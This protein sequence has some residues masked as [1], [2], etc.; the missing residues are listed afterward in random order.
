MA[1]IGPVNRRVAWADRRFSGRAGD[2]AGCD[3]SRGSYSSG[4]ENRI[5]GRPVGAW[6]D[7]LRL[8]AT[9]G[10]DTI[11]KT[12]EWAAANPSQ[13]PASLESLPAWFQFDLLLNQYQT[14][15]KTRTDLASFR[16][17]AA[18][19]EAS[20]AVRTFLLRMDEQMR[21]RTGLSTP[22]RA[23]VSL[24][25]PRPLGDALS[26]TAMDGQIKVTFIRV[27][28]KDPTIAPFYMGTTEVSIG[29]F[30]N[31]IAQGTPG[32]YFNQVSQLLPNADTP[33]RWIGP[34]GWELDS[35]RRL[36]IPR[37]NMWCDDFQFKNGQR[38]IPL[39]EHPMQYVTPE[40]ALY[41]ARLIGCRPSHR[42]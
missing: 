34:H 39:P 14:N 3:Q 21:P 24:G 18:K 41:L 33:P 6:N 8:A 37:R 22:Q 31:V 2:R 27:Q 17:N 13:I 42:R 23:A 10:A 25:R 28:P 5:A 4:G 26:Y 32:R 30:A 1:A 29:L 40:A 20:P 36:L 19:L 11:R 16:T 35:E 15:P 7:H 9:A 38:P 12:V